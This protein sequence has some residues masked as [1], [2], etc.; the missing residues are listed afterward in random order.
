[1]VGTGVAVPAPVVVGVGRAVA[2]G[3]AV[4]VAVAAAVGAGVG[5]GVAVGVST[6]ALGEGVDGVAAGP[7]SPPHA[8]N[9]AAAS[10]KAAGSRNAWGRMG[11]LT[12]TSGG[13]AST[14]GN[15]AMPSP[16]PALA[17]E[18]SRAPP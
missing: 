7:D 17:V 4:G 13:D 1:M 3:V 6:A 12:R 18:G 2:P 8:P 9:T 10:R 5:D 16:R 15:R 14:L 11:R